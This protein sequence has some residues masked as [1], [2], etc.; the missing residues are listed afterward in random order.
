[1]NIV[2]FMQCSVASF[3]NCAN[4]CGTHPSLKQV[5]ECQALF[6][7]TKEVAGRKQKLQ[8][9]TKDA[10]FEWQLILARVGQFNLAF[11]KQLVTKQAVH[12]WVLPKTREPVRLLTK[13]TFHQDRGRD[14][15]R[16]QEYSTSEFDKMKWPWAEVC[17]SLIS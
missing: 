2:L 7:F 16:F 13:N 5:E 4:E 8:F 12:R 17:S 15:Y 10:S 11:P 9:N 14:L 3:D 1:M 6:S